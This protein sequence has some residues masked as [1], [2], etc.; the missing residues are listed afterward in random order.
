MVLLITVPLQFLRTDSP[1]L[2]S[3]MGPGTYVTVLCQQGSLVKGPQTGV[4]Y[5]I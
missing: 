2:S 5:Q 4:K 3:L 1:L